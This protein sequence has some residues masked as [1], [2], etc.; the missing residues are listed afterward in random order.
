MAC[1]VSTRLTGLQFLRALAACMVLIGHVIA[2]AE[3]YFG[4]HLPGDS[5]PWTRGVGLFFVISG[6]VIA[7]SAQRF[8][9]QPISF[10]KRRL[11]RVVPLYY[12]FTTLMVAVLLLL[13]GAAK[14]TSL[15]VGQILSSYGFWPYARDDGRIA[16]VLSL[17]WTLNYELF[18][19][20]LCAICLMLRRSFLALAAVMVAFVIGGLIYPGTSVEFIFWTNPLILEFLF[21]VGLARLYQSGWRRARIGYAFTGTLFGLI[22]L[23]L[24][25]TTDL[26][27]VLAAG[28][29][30]T[31]IVAS[32]TL[33]CPNIKI[34]GQLLG[35]ASY[36]LYLSHRFSLRAATL[37]IMPLLPQTQWGAWIYVG[38]VTS[39]SLAIGVLTHLL[40]E[41]PMMR[42][43]SAPKNM[44]TA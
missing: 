25:D 41:R 13:P 1:L 20:A 2:E 24:F 19:Y 26:P 31:V 40:L 33:L 17:G 4:F 14:D 30:A 32:G 42:A 18:F 43:L 36:A 10:L 28:L 12:I 15:D 3:H 38:L 37:L 11:L 23:I 27:R 7:F 35:Y 34:P 5:I 6:F 44:V 8:Q 9:A 21:G 39:L 22:L 16:P 29:P